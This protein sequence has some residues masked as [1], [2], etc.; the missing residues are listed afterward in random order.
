MI[1]KPYD[2]DQPKVD[3]IRKMFNRIAPSYDKL[4]RII[5]LGMDVNWRKKALRMVA[6]FS[7]KKILDVATGTG[8][9]A[10]EM[11]ENIPEIES[12]IGIDISEEMLRQGL[13][14]I[15]QLGLENVIELQKQDCLHTI[16]E[17][18]SFD[19]ITIAF[20]LRNF[21]N[22]QDSLTELYRIIKPGTPLMIIE[23]CEPK[24]RFVKLLYN[25]YVYRFIP[26]IGN[27]ISHDKDA[28]TYLPKSIA[29]VPQR[30]KLVTLLR[31][32]GFGEAYYHSLPPGTC[33][34]YMAIK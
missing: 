7:P 10:I 30:E 25:T 19:A 27:M 16:F 29:A 24:N 31:D 21:E 4:N 28:Y 9:L 6:P 14:K 11:I 26:F 1:I 5:S 13:K 15:R 18:D 17:N 23:L 34:I 3:Q 12:I 2:D 32:A 20:G 33:S 22:I 8:D